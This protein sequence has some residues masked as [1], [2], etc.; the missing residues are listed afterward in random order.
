MSFFPAL[1][2]AGELS[3]TCEYCFFAPYVGLTWG[4]GWSCCFHG[5]VAGTGQGLCWCSWALIG[6]LFVRCSPTWWWGHNIVCCPNCT[7]ICRIVALCQVDA[8]HYFFPCF[9]PQ[10]RLQLGWRKLVMCCVSTG[11]VLSC[12]DGIHVIVVVSQAVAGQWFRPV[13]GHTCPFGSHSRHI[14]PVLQGL[15]DGSAW[16]HCWACRQFVVTCI[17][18]GPWGCWG[19]H[20][21]CPLSYILCLECWWCCVWGAWL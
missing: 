13:V 12:F 21:L 9:L 17:H 7:S 18:I 3:S 20:P 15:W 2:R 14:H 1:L 16:W 10:S 11:Q 6:E 4:Y 19:K 5:G 8:V